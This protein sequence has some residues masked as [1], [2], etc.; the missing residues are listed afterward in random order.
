MNTPSSTLQRSGA[1]G[2]CL[3]LSIMLT[4]LPALITSPAQGKAVR[5]F[6]IHYSQ[7]A[8]FPRDRVYTHAQYSPLPTLNGPSRFHGM[9]IQGALSEQ[10][11]LSLKGLGSLK[12]KKNAEG[13]THFGG[14][15]AAT[16]IEFRHTVFNV[17]F[18]SG[19][20]WLGCGR[21]NFTASTAAGDQTVSVFSDAI[22]IEYQLNI[23][24]IFFQRLVIA[25]HGSY[26]GPIVGTDYRIGDDNLVSAFPTG[27][28][29]GGSVGYQFPFFLRGKGA[30]R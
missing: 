30:Q 7:H 15:L 9:F 26:M 8:Y 22:F 16:G 10:I 17:L 1:G 3:L 29:L 11:I 27:F 6:S 4:A 12:D 21:F 23:G 5:P 13:Y 19:G 24:A 18:L 28:V 14:G 2:Q 25:I 20:L